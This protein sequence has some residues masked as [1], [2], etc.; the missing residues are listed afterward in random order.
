MGILQNQMKAHHLYQI[1]K[2]DPT[3]LPRNL[4]HA[5]LD[6]PPSAFRF[7]WTNHRTSEGIRLGRQY[8]GWN[9]DVRRFVEV[10]DWIHQIQISLSIASYPP[11]C[12]WPGWW[13]N[14]DIIANNDST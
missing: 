4:Q 11:G 10:R 13:Y 5:N 6:Y 7:P 14:R 3:T 9:V 1:R 2:P 8:A 12:S